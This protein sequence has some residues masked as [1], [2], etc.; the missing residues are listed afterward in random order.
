[1][2]GFAEG[3]E[4]GSEGDFLWLEVQHQRLGG[5]AFTELG[6]GGAGVNFAFETANHDLLQAA[7]LGFAELVGLAEADGVENFKQAREAACVA[8][9]WCGAEEEAVFELRC[10]QTQH[11]AEVAVFAE[12]GGHQVVALVDDEHIPGQVR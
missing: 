5:K 7:A 6:G 1:M 12:G 10:Q 8:V 2:N 11:L 4:G 9:V 3:V